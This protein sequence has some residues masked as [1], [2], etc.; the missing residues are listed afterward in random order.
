M[1]S[2]YFIAIVTLIA[3]IAAW[4]IAIKQAKEQQVPSPERKEIKSAKKSK[5]AKKEP[6]S[7]PR[8]KFELPIEEQT[9]A[10][11]EVEVPFVPVAVSKEVE[12]KTFLQPIVVSLEEGWT[13][14]TEK[15]QISAASYESKLQKVT[16]ELDEIRRSYK[17][18]SKNYEEQVQKSSL[19]ER[20]Y[21]SKFSSAA[22]RIQALENELS[23]ALQRN[24]ELNKAAEAARRE[25]DCLKSELV[26]SRNMIIEWNA[27]KD[28]MESKLNLLMN[29][30]EENEK[31]SMLFR[32][33]LNDLSRM[34][35]CLS[36]DLKS[37][38]D[39]I[40][41]AESAQEQG[42]IQLSS[43]QKE[44]LQ[45]NEKLAE[46]KNSMETLNV[47]YQNLQTISKE[48]ESSYHEKIAE[49]S[50]LLSS[51]SERIN[52][53]AEEVKE[54]EA[55]K[56]Q[57]QQELNKQSS[58]VSLAEENAFLQESCDILMKFISIN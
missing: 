17:V 11:K 50:E 49:F 1:E 34:N 3:C 54:K 19:I 44:N 26:M 7:K 56:Q 9:V 33:K 46:L 45:L 29:E 12:K 31:Q 30:K 38:K 40:A 22:A 15:G 4:I 8:V 57:L 18:V 39:K 10:V 14:V 6:S 27:E 32:T 24:Q 25:V 13:G 51:S 28:S 48:K 20:E 55:E 42:R 5:K 58:D 35:E 43:M 53:F 21:K 41:I 16:E 47:Q 36:S 37:A 52:A 23:V 2:V